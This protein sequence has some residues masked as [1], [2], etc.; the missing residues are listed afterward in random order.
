MATVDN[1]EVRV[2][3]ALD[4]A[5]MAA[6][7]LHAAL[8]DAVVR[9]GGAVR[10]DFE[11]LPI[12]ARAIADQVG[13]SLDTQNAVARQALGEAAIFLDATHANIAEALRTS[14]QATEHLIRQAISDARQAVGKISEAVAVRRAHSTPPAPAE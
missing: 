1:P 4:H 11:A 2:R 5:R 3:D 13:Q 14:G 10:A 12:R 9:H 7:D 8:T 6:Q